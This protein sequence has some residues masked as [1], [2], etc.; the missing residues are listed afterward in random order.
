VTSTP[1]FASCVDEYLISLR[2]ERGLAANTIAAYGRDLGQY[3]E[4][5]KG[6]EPDPEV[7]ES[8]VSNLHTT[9]IARSS[10]ARKI[11]SIRGLHRFLVVEGFRESDPTI[12]LQTPRRGEPLPKA[13]TVDE[14]IALVESPD[15]DTVK[16]RRN[17]ALLEFLYGTGARVS[18][19]VGLDLTHVDLDDAIAIVT[20]KGSKQR[21][22]PLGGKAVEALRRWLPD[23]LS[24]VSRDQPG[25]P[26]FVN[27]RGRR[28]SRQGIFDIVRESAARSGID[29]EAVSPHVLRHSAA[30]HMVERGADLRTVQEMLGQASIRTTQIYTRVS[31]AHLMEIYIEAHPRSK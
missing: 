17:S 3:V 22:V 27:L 1:S 7:V 20:G 23:R 12:L 6:R 5:L 18:E 11:A 30:T 24:L 14:A 31:A 26:M 16:G 21:I 13:L 29:P 15:L 28:L 10:L 2:V 8:W 19:V 4:F 25:D 9:G